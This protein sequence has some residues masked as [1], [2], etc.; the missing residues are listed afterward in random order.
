MALASEK[1][2][3][4]VRVPAGEFRMG[5]AAGSGGLPDEQ[6]ERSVLLSA[7]YIDRFEVSNEAYRPLRLHDRPP[8][9]GK[10][11]SRGDALEGSET[12]AGHR[13]ASRRKYQLGR[14]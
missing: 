12:D 8:D 14:C 9:A 5:A 3:D 1:P 6:P 4:M 13:T 2:D 10:F 7:F 11:Q